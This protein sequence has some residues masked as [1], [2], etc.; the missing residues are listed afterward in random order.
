MYYTMLPAYTG[1]ANEV[2]LVVRYVPIDL[3]VAKHAV[4]ESPGRY[5]AGPAPVNIS[6]VGL[7][8]ASVLAAKLAIL[9]GIPLD[10]RA[11]VLPPLKAIRR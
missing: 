9:P 1:K 3:P 7:P 11:V 4:P 6:I 5:H 10:T 8:M 2:R